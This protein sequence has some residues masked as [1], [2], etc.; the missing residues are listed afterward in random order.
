LVGPVARSSKLWL[1][2]RQPPLQR[3]AR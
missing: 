3:C 2:S 1:R